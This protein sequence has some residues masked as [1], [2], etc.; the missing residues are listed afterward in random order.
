VQSDQ[1][2]ATSAPTLAEVRHIATLIR[3]SCFSTDIGCA[4]L[5][6]KVDKVS[7]RGFVKIVMLS[8]PIAKDAALGS[9]E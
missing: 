8:A 7:S 5:S 6:G 4:Q 1:N 9:P 2:S 3:R